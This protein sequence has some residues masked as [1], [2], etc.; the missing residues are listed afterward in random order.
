MSSVIIQLTFLFL[1]QRV[2]SWR[3][4]QLQTLCRRQDTIA[5][6]QTDVIITHTYLLIY[7]SLCVPPLDKPPCSIILLQL[8][9]LLLCPSF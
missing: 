2:T 3:S 6:R 4:P 7:T 5:F 8:L 9:L 1:Y